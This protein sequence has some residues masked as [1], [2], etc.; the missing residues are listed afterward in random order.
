VKSNVET[1]GPTQVKVSVEVPFD[2]LTPA[3]DAAYKKIARSVKVQG[4]RPGKVPPRI[5]DQRVGR[6][7]VLEEAVN[8]AMPSSTPTPSSRLR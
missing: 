4:F 2:E 8:D 5:L 1:L 3:I 6:P 7:A